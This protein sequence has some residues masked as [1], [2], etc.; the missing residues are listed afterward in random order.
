MGA[1]ASYLRAF[2]VWK[3]W[4]TR[5]QAE[6]HQNRIFN[7]IM[8]V[9]R[10]AACFRKAQTPVKSQRRLIRRA[11]LQKDLCNLGRDKLGGQLNKK[12][13]RR[14]NELILASRSQVPVT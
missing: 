11:D 5:P 8:V 3:C 13:P 10:T 1:G 6:A 4:I 12:P 14:R 7:R 2:F 9:A